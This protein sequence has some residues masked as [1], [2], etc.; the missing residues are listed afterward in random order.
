[1]SVLIASLVISPLSADHPPSPPFFL[2]L[3]FSQ[4][5]VPNCFVLYSPLYFCWYDQLWMLPRRSPL[6]PVH[7]GALCITTSEVSHKYLGDAESLKVIHRFV[8]F[9]FQSRYPI[10]LLVLGPVTQRGKEEL[11]IAKATS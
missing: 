9:S 7:L 4:P 8:P 6:L 10:K 11:L 1:M 3:S 2:L 5:N